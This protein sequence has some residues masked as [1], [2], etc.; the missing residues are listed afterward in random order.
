MD[1]IQDSRVR[2]RR[3]PLTWIAVLV[4]GFT[5][6]IYL[7]VSRYLFLDDAFIHLRIA[8][9]L[10]A[11]GFYSFNGDKPAYCTS[12]PLFTAL[13]ALGSRVYAGDFLPKIVDLLT[14]IALFAL[15]AR[16]VFAART[17]SAAALAVVF[18]AAIAS[19]LAMRW[20]TDGMETGLAGVF[21]LL[22]AAAAFDVYQDL[23]P[24]SFVEQVGYAIF[25]AFA[26]TLRVEFCFLIAAIGVASLKRSD[27]AGLN[28]RAIGLAVGA[29][30]GLAVVYGVF[31]ALLPDTAVAKSHL[32]ADMPRLQGNVA[33]LLDIAKAHAAASSLGLLVLGAGVLSCAA[34]LHRAQDRRF[35]MILNASFPLLL[36]LVVWRQQA[37]QGY[38]Y[39]VFIEFF[40][41]AFNIAVLDAAPGPAVLTAHQPN[42]AMPGR[43]SW[44]IP[45]VALLGLAFVGWQ[46]FDLHK[47]EIIAEGRS[48]SFEKFESLNLEDLRGSYG[49]AWDVGMI[50]YFSHANILDAN[51]LVDGRDVAR[52]SKAAR[53]HSFVD[54]HPIRFVFAD[55]DQLDELKQYLDV[56]G[57]SVRE[58]FDFPN[59]SGAADRHFLLVRPRDPT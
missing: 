30:A 22:L 42:A 5:A 13:L 8:R 54:S 18:L 10:A 34:A 47:L 12:S 19:P 1:A 38:R 16:R 55:A 20:L 48:A 40:L 49:I 15:A 56:G 11:F 43:G 32:M 6:T 23:R 17:G 14:Y 53:L 52:L 25:A 45:V 21:A 51:G 9:S 24:V 39:F 37:V 4:F 36:L 59:F 7:W 57:W 3:V 2:S 50:G 35:V 58:A 41:L 29:A 26:A 33:T 31:G 28:P 46:A 44:S 27:P